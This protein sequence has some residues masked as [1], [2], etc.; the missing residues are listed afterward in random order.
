V[1][2]ALRHGLSVLL[3]EDAIRAVDVAPGDGQRA[4][5]EMRAAGAEVV[6]SSAI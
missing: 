3:V 5:D 4:L 6:R 2:D 1:L